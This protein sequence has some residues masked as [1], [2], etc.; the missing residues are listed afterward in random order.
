[1]FVAVCYRRQGLPLLSWVSTPAELDPSQNRAEEF[2]ILGVGER[3][4]R[5]QSVPR[6]QGRGAG[7]SQQIPGQAGQHER[8][9]PAL[10]NSSAIKGRSTPAGLPAP[11]KCTSHLGFGLVLR[12]HCNDGLIG[13]GPLPGL[14][15]FTETMAKQPGV[16]PVISRML[17]Y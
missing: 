11:G 10:P 13:M 16:S 3:G 7:E 5:R 8:R 9:S 1:M 6:K 2:F 14:T 12:N 4:S 15:W 17:V